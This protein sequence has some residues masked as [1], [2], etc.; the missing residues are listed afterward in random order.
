VNAA[1]A[2]S[3]RSDE[4]FSSAHEQMEKM[5]TEL[6]SAETLS[7]QHSEVESF[8]REQGRELERRLYQAHLDLRAER[9]RPVPVRGADQV[10]RTYRRP[11]GRPLGTILGRVLVGRLAYQAV[12]VESLHPMDAALNLP[13]ELY[14]HGVSQF[15]AEH[16]AIMSFD[17]VVG[18]LLTATGTAIG[19]RQVE[20]MAVR[21]AVDFEAFYQRRRAANDVL[22]ET[23]DP[24]VLTCDGKG[25]VM[26]P[27]DLRPATKKAA[28]KKV[29]KLATRLTSG[30]KRNRKR[31]AEVAAIYTVARHV[32]TPFDV[33]ADLHGETD[34]EA[35]RARRARR[36]KARNKRV[37]ASVERDLRVVIEELFDDA[38]ARDPRHRRQWVALIDGNKEQIAT[39][40]ATAKR[41]AMPVC[42]I[43]DLMHVLEYLWR[44]AHAFC[45]DG[46]NEAEAWVQ[47]HLLLL[48]QGRPAGEV[49]TTMRQSARAMGLRGSKLGAV[50]DTA[51]YLHDYARYI[52]YGEAIQSGLPIATGVI[53]GA[54]RYL[55]KDRMDRGGA[56]W[57]LVGAEAVLRLRALRASGDFADYWAFHLGEEL[58]RNHAVHYVHARLPDP[59]R[60]L[61]SVK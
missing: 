39:I 51:D 12:G 20:E 40:E 3:T 59:L 44:A 18:E 23:R 42:I 60:P 8:V 56:R 48:L 6:R 35:R 17:D 4:T 21:A 9:E 33:L 52:R 38:V 46:T 29:R 25:V 5:V 47:R 19:K 1:Y 16:A 54:C 45:G 28:R 57:T 27:E 32:R 50:H 30:E 14:S 36:P 26:V 53:E 37:W 49:A 2:K 10:E 15:V 31:M 43:V 7:A 55:V 24:L 11:S 22:E 61:R 41:L 58:Q 13:P 34:P